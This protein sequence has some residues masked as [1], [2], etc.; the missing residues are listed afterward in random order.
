LLD[1][2]IPAALQCDRTEV[3]GFEVPI[4]LSKHAQGEL[5]QEYLAGGLPG[6]AVVPIDVE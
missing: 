2:L 6:F 5:D 1:E 4:L 3:A